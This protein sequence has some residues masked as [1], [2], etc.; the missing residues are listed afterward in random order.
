MAGF[1]GVAADPVAI[2]GDRLMG[3]GVKE[4]IELGRLPMRLL[5]RSSS[6]PPQASILQARKTN[7]VKYISKGY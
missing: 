3:L 4:F 7:M 6:L 5:I 1:G 2:E